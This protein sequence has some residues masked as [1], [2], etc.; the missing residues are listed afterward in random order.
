MW[1]SVFVD[2]ISIDQPRVDV[3]SLET[4][5]AGFK[6]PKTVCI[7]TYMG[8]FARRFMNLGIGPSCSAV[9]HLV[10]LYLL[11]RVQ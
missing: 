4:A 8:E 9:A 5:S 7:H 1:I 6:V 11:Q 2:L 3:T 10:I